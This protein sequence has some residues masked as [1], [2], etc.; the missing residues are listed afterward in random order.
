MQQECPSESIMTS[1]RSKHVAA[2][3]AVAAAAL[4]AG[5][6]ALPDDSPVVE[7]LDEET[8]LTIARLGH[9]IEL[10]RE[11]FRPDTS[12][13]FAFIGPF[14]TNSMGKRDLFLWVALPLEK[15]ESQ[16]T[17]VIRVNG[18]QLTLGAPGRNPDTAGLHQSPYKIPTHWIAMFYYP[19]DAAMVTTLGGAQ[20]I[21]IQVT[22][23]T[24]SGQLKTR[25]TGNIAT[26]PRLKAFES[27]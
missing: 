7:Q 18:T 26:D 16:V 3:V 23:D 1:R 27:R 20:N 11:N 15:P 21:D 17:P 12:G 14:E 4:L 19:I 2:V 13:K 6:A 9:P 10:Y 8:G 22:E 25:Y 5:C 24:P